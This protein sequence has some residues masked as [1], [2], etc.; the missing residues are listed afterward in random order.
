[1]GAQG[2]LPGRQVGRPRDR[3][4]DRGLAPHSEQPLGSTPEAAPADV[5]RAV[6]AARRAFDT[7]PWPRTDPAERLA[8][9]RCL[10]EAYGARQEE[11]CE[12]ISTELGAPLWFSQVGQVAPP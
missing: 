8:A 11:L 6:E 1:V 10:V 7:G 3:A 5:D 12:L 4:P 9:V 2:A